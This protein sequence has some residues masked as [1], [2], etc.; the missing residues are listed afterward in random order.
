[1]TEYLPATSGLLL[2]LFLF[3]AAEHALKLGQ[4]SHGP[5]K[6]YLVCKLNH[7]SLMLIYKEE[8][9]DNAV[10]TERGCGYK[11]EV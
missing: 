3:A 6:N 4:I 10:A 8:D 1:M 5:N 11:H 7:S 9:A 2:Y